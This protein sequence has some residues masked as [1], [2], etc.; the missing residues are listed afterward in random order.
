MIVGNSLFQ[1]RSPNETLTVP[2]EKYL[3]M[4]IPDRTISKDLKVLYYYYYQIFIYL[5]SVSICNDISIVFNTSLTNM[6][7]CLMKEQ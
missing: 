3:S 1:T 2:K 6:Q 5:Y 7:K 4:R